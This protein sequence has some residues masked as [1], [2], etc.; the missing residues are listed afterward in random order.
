MIP[1]QIREIGTALYTTVNAT[2]VTNAAR[3][4]A[5]DL[6]D[7]K[8][9]TYEF[10]VV[11]EYGEHHVAAAKIKVEIEIDVYVRRLKVTADR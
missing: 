2:S 9:T 7:G 6:Y 11:D 1:Y 5:R 4:Y 3:T 10:D 8:E